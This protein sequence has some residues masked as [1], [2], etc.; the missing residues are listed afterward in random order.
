MGLLYAVLTRSSTTYYTAEELRGM[1]SSSYS[2]ATLGTV[3]TY[4]SLEDPAVLK[5]T[6]ALELRRLLEQLDVTPDVSLVPS[7]VGYGGHADVF[8]GVWRPPG[9]GNLP[10]LVWQPASVRPPGADTHRSP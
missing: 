10:A 5:V 7:P 9:S 1:S 6:T 4:Y 3:S 8:S 2:L